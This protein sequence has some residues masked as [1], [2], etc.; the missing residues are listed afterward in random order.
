MEL[1]RGTFT[2]EILKTNMEII[3]VSNKDSGFVM[4]SMRCMIKNA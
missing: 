2:V 4:N 1:V 3:H